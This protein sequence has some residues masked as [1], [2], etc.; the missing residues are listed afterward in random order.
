[1]PR[2]ASRTAGAALA[3]A[4][5]TLAA[6]AGQKVCVFDIVGATEFREPCLPQGS[7]ALRQPQHSPGTK[8]QVPIQQVLLL[9]SG[10]L[11]DESA[12]GFLHAIAR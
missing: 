11:P 2:G 1:M 4:A 7:A 5:C 3:L 12:V 8:E 9:C 10:P 6:Q